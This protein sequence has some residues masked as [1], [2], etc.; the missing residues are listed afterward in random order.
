MDDGH[1]Q[2]LDRDSF[3]GHVARTNA[4]TTVVSFP[5]VYTSEWAML[6]ERS[7]KLRDA[8]KKSKDASGEPYHLGSTSCVFLPPGSTLFGL[9]ERDPDSTDGSCWCQ[10]LYGDRQEFGCRWF[11]EWLK[12]LDKALERS[13]K[14]MVV[15]KAGDKS[16]GI[17]DLKWPPAIACTDANRNL[18]GLGVSQRGEVAFM[19]HKKGVALE[20]E[21]IQDF[22][23][24]LLAE[25]EVEIG[26]LGVPTCA[27]NHE[28]DLEANEMRLRIKLEDL[29]VDISRRKLDAE[30]LPE[31]G[32]G[33]NGH[34]I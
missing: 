6:V 4:I 33:K 25:I 15:F 1:E 10:A 31:A 23:K 22:R 2:D 11:S 9:H 3:F 30:Q 18:E 32:Q 28:L 16:K 24:R 21:D 26:Q 8:E 12:Q 14:L 20:H 29:L 27:Q 34:A 19:M 7:G 13:H 17:K 5:G